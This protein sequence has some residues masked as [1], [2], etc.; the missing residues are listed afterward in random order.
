[1][2]RRDFFKLT[3]SSTV[4]LTISGCSSN[5]QRSSGNKPT[6]KPNV[7]LIYVDDLGTLDANCYGTDYLHTP[8]IDSLA[9]SGIR[10]TQ[11]YAHTVCCPSR[12]G[13]LTG[14]YPQ[15]AGVGDWC[16]N[17]PGDTNRGHPIEGMPKEEVTLAEVLKKAGYRTALFGKWHLGGKEGYW[18]NDQGFDEFFGHLSGG[19]D[20]YTH[21][22][23]KGKNPP[24]DLYRNG[25]EVFEDGKYFPDL[26]VR[27]T[28]RFLEDNKDR[29]FFLYLP[30][31]MV[32][33]PH[34]PDLEIE[35][36]YQHLSQPHRKYRAYISTLD[37][38]IGRI[39]ALL[40]K[41]GLLNNTMII[42]QS[43]NG[44][45][46]RMGGNAG[47]WRGA[48]GSLLEAGIRIPTIVCF[49]HHIPE[50]QVRDQV[51]TNMDFF[52]TILKLCNLPLP[53]RKI[54]GK[55]ILP[56]LRS[57]AAP[58][59]HEVLHWQWP[60]WGSD[61]QQWAVRE[62]D[63]KLIVNGLNASGSELESPFLA[64]LADDKPEYKN[65]ASENPDIVGRLTKLHEEW[66]RDVT[67]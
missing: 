49:P 53:D 36:R 14:R 41:R 16:M 43:D 27:E 29:P 8:N 28:N 63:W 38:R 7:I 24:H 25:K 64:S 33:T 21:R 65:Y 34:Q 39:K 48:K 40:S 31:D 15:R 23:I 17:F 66:T 52:P 54:D 56:V 51:I 47:K 55:N 67:K 46:N 42:F 50:G 60:I 30:F 62:G 10:F 5:F 45:A 4:T 22:Y 35:K 13:L 58:S 12:A 32:H 59:P 26:L 44:H 11:A 2:N 20:A 6:D 18:P 9:K 57:A 37:D 3:I 1:M 19:I 61:K